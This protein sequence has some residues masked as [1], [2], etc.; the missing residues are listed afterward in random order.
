MR[1]PRMGGVLGVGGVGGMGVMRETGGMKRERGDDA[2][3]CEYL[4]NDGET[5]RGV[6]W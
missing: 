4:G 6:C 5:G 2:V 3:V 1:G